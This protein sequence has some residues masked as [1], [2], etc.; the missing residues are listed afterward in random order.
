MTTPDAINDPVY[1]RKRLRTIRLKANVP[2]ADKV[3]PKQIQALAKA[4]AQENVRIL[5]KNG[6][7]ISPDGTVDRPEQDGPAEG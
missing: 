2:P 4:A 3:T 5:L 6:L 7:R 1:E